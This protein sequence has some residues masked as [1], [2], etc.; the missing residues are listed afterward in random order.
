MKKLTVISGKGG[1]GKTSI[2]AALSMLAKAPVIADCDVDAAD[3]HLILDPESVET[4]DF[5]GGKIAV[6]DESKCTRCGLCESLCR[7]DAIHDFTVDP[8]SCEGCAFCARTCPE[9]AIAMERAI[10]GRWFISHTRAGTMTHA[11]LGIAEE[12]SGKLVTLV[13]QLASNAAEGEAT[14]TIITDGPPGI[15]CPVIASITGADLLLAVTEPTL[16]GI[17]DLKRVVDVAA[18]FD[19]PVMV[20]INKCDINPYNAST[21]EEYCAAKGLDVAGKIRYDPEVTKAMIL[22]K[23]V[24]EHDCGEVTAE[25]KKMWERIR[26]RLET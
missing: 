17:H 19:I 26:G 25:V 18:H 3:L 24:V 21:I 9:E 23:S 8:V 2:T 11:R 22:R 4:G 16:S 6:I 12:N 14:P 5:L 15:G 7:F 1:T 10:S 13:R 20:C